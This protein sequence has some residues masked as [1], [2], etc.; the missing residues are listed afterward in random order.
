VTEPAAPASDAEL[1]DACRR[2]DARAWRELVLRFERLVFTVPR[3]AGLA[4]DEA[5][6]VFQTVFLRLHQHLGG[7]SQPERVRAWLVTTARRET[8][9]QLR[10]RRRTVPLVT[11][12]D[13]GAEEPADPDPLPEQLLEQLQLQHHARVAFERLS[14]PCRA[15]LGLLYAD[16]DAPPYGDIATR[17]GMPVGSIGPTRARCLAKLRALMDTPG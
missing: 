12:D 14:A 9:K 3:R 10:E 11:D 17:L 2:G 8:L 7:L 6:D 5:A 1:I 16:D 4:A 15:L 13:G